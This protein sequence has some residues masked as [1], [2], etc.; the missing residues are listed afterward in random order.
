MKCILLLLFLIFSVSGASGQKCVIN[1]ADISMSEIKKEFFGKGISDFFFFVQTS[2]EHLLE[3]EEEKNSERWYTDFTG[4]VFW[5]EDTRCFVKK[6][7]YY[8]SY[9]SMELTDFNG[10]D[11]MLEHLSAFK[12]ETVKPYQIRSKKERTTVT[13]PN[14]NRYNFYFKVG[15]VEFE[16]QI[17]PYDLTQN[18]TTDATLQNINYLKNNH[19]MIVKLYQI[20]LATVEELK[21]KNMTRSQ[22]KM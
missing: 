21:S 6:F 12:A 13:V 1:K 7:D 19:L 4:Y 2:P 8:S 22:V 9:N 17:W 3:V 18:D 14:Q 10:Y 11:F 20:C 5:Q 16:K 15:S